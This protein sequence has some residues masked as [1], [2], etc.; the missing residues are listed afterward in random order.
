MLG[1]QG[2]A[3]GWASPGKGT[4]FPG[5]QG[6]EPPCCLPRKV[7]C[8]ITIVSPLPVSSH[9]QWRE[10]GEKLR[11][12]APPQPGGPGTTFA[13]WAAT[14]CSA[15]FVPLLPPAGDVVTFLGDN[16]RMV[17]PD[18][19]FRPYLQSSLG[20]GLIDFFFVWDQ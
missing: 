14:F 2:Y 7:G 20:L 1:P 13:S 11:L 12:E 8:D 18:K 19:P 6:D 16:A 5:P 3:Q 9:L 17:C 10:V 15:P 4:S